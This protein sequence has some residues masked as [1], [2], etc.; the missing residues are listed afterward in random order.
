MDAEMMWCKLLGGRMT[1][2]CLLTAALCGC[3][4]W[5]GWC[6]EEGWWRAEG[7]RAGGGGGGGAA[8]AGEGAAAAGWA[9]L[10][11][12]GCMTVMAADP[13]WTS[14]AAWNLE[15]ADCDG[16]VMMWPDALADKN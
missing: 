6:R 5:W 1:A 8:A 14:E 3:W 15:A 7:A 16:K 10:A 2:C 12:A 13:E 11:D 9:G 4:G